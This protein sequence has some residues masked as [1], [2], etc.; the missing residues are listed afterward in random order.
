MELYAPRWNVL[1]VN[2]VHHHELIKRVE[3]KDEIRYHKRA[4]FQQIEELK[5][6]DFMWDRTASSEEKK[7]IINLLNQ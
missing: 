3:T 6:F 7:Q 1:K 5:R 4:I 2:I